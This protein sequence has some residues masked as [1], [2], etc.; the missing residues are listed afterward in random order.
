MKDVI[1]AKR[2]ARALFALAKEL[3]KIDII[4]NE[5]IQIVKFVNEDAQFRKFLYH[6]N[7]QSNKKVS[8]IKE[9]FEGKISNTLLNTLVIL[10]EN[11]RIELIADLVSDYVKLAN[12]ELN[13][14]QAV[15][16]SS[17]PIQESELKTIVH[18][19][20]QLTGKKIRAE[21][22]IDK[23]LFGG[24]Q[25]RIGDRLYDGTISGKLKQLAKTL[26]HTQVM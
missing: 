23:T 11:R 16:Y 5:L 12:N 3:N 18:K 15:I 17:H 1:V 2:Y 10:V 9:L 7:I 21:V 19:F 22:R 24:I 4:E 14:A 8:L 20:S 25:V 26:A 6:P 13:Q